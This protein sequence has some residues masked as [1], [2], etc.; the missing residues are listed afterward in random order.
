MARQSERQV[1][2]SSSGAR[3]APP[4]MRRGPGME[5]SDELYARQPARGSRGGRL[6]GGESCLNVLH[7][8]VDTTRARVRR[9][10]HTSDDAKAIE[11]ADVGAAITAF[12]ADSAAR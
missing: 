5:L 1:R 3:K 11:R 2:R 6:K 7:L 4:C 9:S 12:M 8:G 10:L